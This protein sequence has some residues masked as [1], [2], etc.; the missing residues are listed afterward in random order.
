MPVPKV[1]ATL[2]VTVV[3]VTWNCEATLAGCLAA[4]SRSSPAAPARVI[5]VDNGSTDASRSIAAACGAEVVTMGV[6]AGFP[7]AVNAVLDECTSEFVLLLNP[8]VEVAPDAIA[9]C[10]RALERQPRVGLVGANLRQPDGR[11]DLAA[12]RRF[13]TLGLLAIESLG[14]SQLSRR[15]DP[16]YFPRWDRTDSRPVPCINGAF[17][18]IRTDL[19]R[20]I[21]GLDETAFLYLEDQE[22]CRQVAARGLEVWFAADALAVHRVSAATRAARPDQQAAAYLHRIDA[23]VEI[24]RRIQGAPYAFAA[25]AIWMGRCVIAYVA[26]VVTSDRTGRQRYA[27]ALRWL[28]AQVTGRRPPPPVP[29]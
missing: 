3:V 25:V 7:R 13:R 23:S 26:A 2:P 5:C 21:G 4:V 24:V 10:V 18:L 22:L 11:P 27:S 17:A 28:A 9:T 19:F 1:A 12:A 8:D 15:L 29:S 6:N 20:A 16:Q 14:L